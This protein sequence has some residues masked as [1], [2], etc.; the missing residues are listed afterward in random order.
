MTPQRW[1]PAAP[2]GA[3][4]DPEPRPVLPALLRGAARRCPACGEAELYQSYLKPKTDCDGCGEDLSGHRADDLPPYLTIL[5]AGHVLVPA[6][7]MT[8]RLASPPLWVGY[9]LFGVLA[10]ALC[11]LLLPPIKGAVIALQWAYRMH[12]FD[13]DAARS[14]AAPDRP[15]DPMEQG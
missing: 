13:P 12:G 6:V 10:A 1:E 11:L 14:A 2:E 15:A 4:S 9:L 7:L 8:E 5:V 3:P